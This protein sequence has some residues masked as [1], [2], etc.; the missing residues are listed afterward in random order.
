MAL[1]LS[2]DRE[3]VE[4]Q[5]QLSQAQKELGYCLNYCFALSRNLASAAYIKQRLAEGDIQGAAEAWYELEQKDQ[6]ALN[7][8]PTKGGF[9]STKERELM[10]TS[11]FR[12]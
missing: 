12:P 3:I 11:E 10:K 7:R 6:I 2:I 8:A 1:T 4:L 9:L 5:R